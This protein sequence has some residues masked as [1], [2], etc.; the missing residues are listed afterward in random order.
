[1]RIVTKPILVVG[2]TG[3]IANRLI[4]HLLDHGHRVRAGAR[5][6]SKLNSRSW[7]QHP[8]LEAIP[9][10][11]FDCSSLRKACAGAGAV[12]Y[13]VH[14]MNPG[15]KNFSGADRKAAANITKIAEETKI[16]RIIYLGGLGVEDKTLSHHLRSRREVEEILRSGKAPITVLRAAMIIGAGSASFEILRYLVE[17]LPVMVTP[18]WVST[19]C[20]PIA[21]SNVIE[22]LEKCL[23][24]PATVGETFEIGGGEIVTYLDLMALYAEERKLPRR[25]VIPVPVLT[26]RL[27]SY[28]IH[29]VTPIHA[30]LAR[31][32]AEGLRNEV[33][34]K[35]ERIRTLIPQKLLDLRQAIKRA[36]DQSEVKPGDPDWAGGTVYED[37]RSVTLRAS[38][39][40][41]WNVISKIGQETKWYYADWLWRLRGFFDQLMGGAGMKWHIQK[42]EP[43][44]ELLLLALMKLPGSAV[45][46]FR[47]TPKNAQ[48]T[49][50]TQTAR[51]IPKGLLGILYWYLVFPFHHIIFSGML[52]A[53]AKNASPPRL[54]QMRSF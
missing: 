31:P 48:E 37:S 42:S 7:I 21:V 52:R 32:L 1:M 16:E 8:H 20:E 34:T 14:S 24:I 6:V 9:C 39:E 10:D 18:R 5:S 3:Y 11:V 22:Y 50:L 53:I 44:R 40:K 4:P 19:R 35:D 43:G 47:I 41:I 45:L 12:Y 28:W 54:C 29:L 51:F 38:P 23:S 36:I 13:L 25:F 15:Q 46:D 30:S 33:I 49:E 2:A 26:P 27:S 17:R